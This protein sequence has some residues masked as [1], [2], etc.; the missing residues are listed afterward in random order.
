[1]KIATIPGHNITI[2]Y[3]E[4]TGYCVTYPSGWTQGIAT[5]EEANRAAIWDVGYG[6]WTAVGARAANQAKIK[7]MAEHPTFTSVGGVEVLP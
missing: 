4:E 5:R 2:H 6:E 7:W 3:Y 1:M